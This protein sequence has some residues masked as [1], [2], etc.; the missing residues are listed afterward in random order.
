M[1]TTSVAPNPSTSNIPSSRIHPLMAVAAVSVI[2]LSATGIASI[3]GWISKPQAAVSTSQTVPVAA[4]AALP[5]AAPAPPPSIETVISPAAAPVP[6]PAPKLVQK[7]HQSASTAHKALPATAPAISAPVIT[8]PV[9]AATKPVTASAPAETSASTPTSAKEPAVKVAESAPVIT[10]EYA[11]VESINE[12]RTVAKPSGVGAVAGGVLGAVVGRQIGNGNGRSLG[13]VLGAIG[14]GLA[15]NEIEKRTHVQ[16]HY[17]MTVRYD[18]GSSRT[19]ERATPWVWRV[20]ERIKSRDAESASAPMPA[21][22]GSI[23][24]SQD[25]RIPNGTTQQPSGA[26]SNSGNA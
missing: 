19:F 26:S 15:G 3:T 10:R 22:Q 18:D 4:I 6:T 20:G 24:R 23:N 1:S 7:P 12:V 8:S 14:G 13:T 25:P 2:A 17:Q 9:I 5:T 11:V 21:P 16:S